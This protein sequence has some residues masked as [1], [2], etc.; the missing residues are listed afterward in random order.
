MGVKEGMV[1]RKKGCQGRKGVRKEG[2]QERVTV[3]AVEVVV[4][5]VNEGRASRRGHGD[6]SGGGG[7]MVAA[8]AVV[9]WKT[10]GRKEGMKE[11]GIKKERTERR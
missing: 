11:K 6:G 9:P 3:M 1:S 4:V 2:H 5:A 8:A 10:E 7:L